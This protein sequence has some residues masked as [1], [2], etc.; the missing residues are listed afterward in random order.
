ML[1]EKNCARKDYEEMQKKYKQLTETKDS[2][3]DHIDGY[4]QQLTILQDKI[5]DKNEII[6][7][8][9]KNSRGSNT[10]SHK[11]FGA[12]RDQKTHE[13]IRC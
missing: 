4:N 10:W 8:Q 12:Y 11:S 3:K 2:L 5:K 7:E 6:E 9:K 1:G 13:V